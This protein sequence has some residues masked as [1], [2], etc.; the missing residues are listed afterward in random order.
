MAN[1]KKEPVIS[2]GS[3]GIIDQGLLVDKL[4][5]DLLS[6]PQLD[7]MGYSTVFSQGKCVISK[8]SQVISTGIL[9]NRHYLHSKTD[10]NKNWINKNPQP[11]I[12][13]LFKKNTVT[14]P[15]STPTTA[16]TFSN[17][18]DQNLND[19]TI[20]TPKEISLYDRIIIAH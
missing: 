3:A 1:G 18:P 16:D 7:M 9:F 14:V 15:T 20:S 4:E 8:D 13:S 6:I 2:I 12:E 11:D 5:V 17:D 19:H 10:F